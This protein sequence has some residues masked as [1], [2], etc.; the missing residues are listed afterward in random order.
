ME[1]ILFDLLSIFVLKFCFYDHSVAVS[2]RC[3]VQHIDLGLLHGIFRSQCH[4]Q[5]NGIQLSFAPKGPAQE[6]QFP[7]QTIQDPPGEDNNFKKNH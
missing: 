4:S 2:T 7:Q 1:S 3:Y 6:N 5:P